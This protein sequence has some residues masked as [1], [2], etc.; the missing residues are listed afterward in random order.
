MS[1]A[2][3]TSSAISVL[4]SSRG[5]FEKPSKMIS[6]RIV[7][8]LRMAILQDQETKR[9]TSCVQHMDRGVP[10]CGCTVWHMHRTITHAFSFPNVL[11]E[12]PVIILPPLISDLLPSS[13]ARVAWRCASI[14]C[15]P[16]SQS[17]QTPSLGRENASGHCLSAFPSVSQ[18][19]TFRKDC[20]YFS[21]AI[22]NTGETTP[23]LAEWRIRIG[24]ELHDITAVTCGIASVRA[25]V[26]ACGFPNSFTNE[27]L[28]VL[29]DNFFIEFLAYLG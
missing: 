2:N 1:R 21:W 3:W 12:R 7:H 16:R 29:P 20:K 10:H 5:T 18:R 23:F 26:R 19:D 6:A 27:S 17:Q 14:A 4:A 8:L 9:W 22:W 11:D 25:C 15:A 13:I 24:R 28:L